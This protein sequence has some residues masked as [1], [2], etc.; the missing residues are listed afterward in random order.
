[1][2]TQ[3]PKNKPIFPNIPRSVKAVDETGNFTPQWS[4]A[5]NTLF[6]TLQQFF[7]NEGFGLPQLSI[8]DQNS[9]KDAYN[10]FVGKELPNGTPDIT[11]WR[12]IDAPF[13]D[14]DSGSPTARVPKVFI[15]QYNSDR[16]VASVDWKSYTI[17]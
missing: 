1:M 4:L 5:F 11:G 13:Y 2:T 17:T 15:I 16:T 10:Q 8:D 14:A 7:S 12:I 9:I 3:V 6:Q